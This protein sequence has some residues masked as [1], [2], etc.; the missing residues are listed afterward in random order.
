MLKIVK[1][2]LIATISVL[3]VNYFTTKAQKKASRVANMLA[4]EEMKDY[5]A[6]YSENSENQNTDKIK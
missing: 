3:I 2:S 4:L 6:F 1:D 5:R